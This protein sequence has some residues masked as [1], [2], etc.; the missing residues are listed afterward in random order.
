MTFVDRIKELRKSLH[1]TQSE[2]AERLNVSQGT[3]ASWEN[4]LRIP[5]IQRILEIAEEFNV[6]IDYLFG[7]EKTKE[8]QNQVQL[9]DQEMALLDAY[10]SLNEF[11][12][13]NL[14]GYITALTANADYVQ[15][16]GRSAM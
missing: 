5:E 12:K 8:K 16:S 3:I 15:D 14:S 6:S 1:Y 11:G 2:M 13:G 4:G 7:R 9:T 10:R